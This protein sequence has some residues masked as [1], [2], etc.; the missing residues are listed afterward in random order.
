MAEFNVSV[1]IV[2]EHLSMNDSPWVSSHTKV[3]IQDKDILLGDYVCSVALDEQ[4]V[5]IA[6]ILNVIAQDQAGAVALA[7][8]VFDMLVCSLTFEYHALHAT[9]GDGHIRFAWNVRDVRVL[10]VRHQGIR[11]SATLGVDVARKFEIRQSQAFIDSMRQNSGLEF[12]LQSFR[13][14]LAPVDDRSKYYNAFVV[15]EYIEAKEEQITTKLLN[16]DHLKA[17]V[18]ASKGL[19]ESLGVKR[20]TICR[21]VARVAELK[22]VTVEGR[23]VKLMALLSKRF[24][25]GS[26]KTRGGDVALDRDVV[27]SLIDTRNELFHAKPTGI[28]ELPKKT[29]WLICVVRMILEVL[30]KEARV[31]DSEL[32]IAVRRLKSNSRGDG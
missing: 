31:L 17:L 24:G 2:V 22:K 19:L 30:L 25:I 28:A 16:P 12:L 7:I 14:S 18:D 1:P 5:S 32:S 23:A 6:R 10:D 29:E 4:G 20:D 8:P 15:I 11:V 3:E 9:S 27:Q 21:V 26:I 13:A